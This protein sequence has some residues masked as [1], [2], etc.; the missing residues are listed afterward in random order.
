MPGKPRQKPRKKPGKQQA[1]RVFGLNA[2]RLIQ[3]RPAN[4]HM[5]DG[6]GDGVVCE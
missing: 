6:D 4:A 1:I 5:R 2:M 3:V